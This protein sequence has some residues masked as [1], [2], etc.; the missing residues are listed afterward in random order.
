[1]HS[2]V[3]D[4][5]ALVNLYTLNKKH[6]GLLNKLQFIF[7]EINIPLE[8]KTEFLNYKN[9]DLNRIKFIE[10]IK[11]DRGFIRLCSRFDPIVMALLQAYKDIHV[12]EKEVV[13]QKMK[14]SVYWI[15]SDDRRF[16][17][18]LKAY[19]KNITVI[20]TIG[21]IAML[22]LNELI[23]NCNQLKD[24][25]NKH[26]PFKKEQLRE[27]YE[28]I[29]NHLGIQLDPKKLKKYIYYK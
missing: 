4:N 24:N 3:I 9:N 16:T 26:R 11:L 8:V 10:S 25:L 7:N 18:A 21:I 15:I 22:E 20:N 12:G 23:D 6:P 28:K 5:D 17:I 14:T 19:D 2:A 27:A 29:S 13:A 1:M